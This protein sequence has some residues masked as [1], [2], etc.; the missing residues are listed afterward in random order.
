VFPAIRFRIDLGEAVSVG[1]GKIGLLEAIRDTGSLTSAARALGMSYRRAW[2]LLDSVNRAF[3]SQ[4]AVATTGGAGGGGVELTAFGKTL[5]KSYRSLERDIERAASRN[6]RLLMS[7]VADAGG[8]SAPAA[9]RSLARK[10][11][12]F[13]SEKP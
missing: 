6:L 12:E 1:P 9:R 8:K 13:T 11:Q 10:R 3:S 5:L 2:L 4:V 7:Q